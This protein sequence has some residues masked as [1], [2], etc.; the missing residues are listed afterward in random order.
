MPARQR[1]PSWPTPA[2]SPEGLYAA[3][4]SLYSR[5]GGGRPRLAVAMSGGGNRAAAF[6][7]GVLSGLHQI[8]VLDDVDVISAVSG[9]S[10]ALSWFLLQHYY[11]HELDSTAVPEDRRDE[12][13]FDPGGPYQK[14]LEDHAT[15]GGISEAIMKGSLSAVFDGVLFNALRLPTLVLGASAAHLL[16]E[17]SMRAEYR[18]GLQRTYQ[19]RPSEHSITGGRS[20]RDGIIEAAEHLELSL[21]RP[22]V[23]FP[24]MAEFAQ[25]A[26][27]PA[28]VFNTTVRPPRPGAT[29][30]IGDRLME[31]S[32]AGFGSNSYG[33][34]TWGQTEQFG[35]EP[36]S[37]EPTGDRF[38]KALFR[39]REVSPFAT[40]RSFN[41]APVIS[42]AALSGTNL[43]RATARRLLGLFNFGLEYVVP[44][45][46]SPRRLARISDG[47]HCENLGVYGLLRRQS[48]TILIVDSEY[49][50]RFKFGSLRRLIDAAETELNVK[51]DVPDI[52]K[53]DGGLPSAVMMGTMRR[54]RSSDSGTI[55]Y[56]KL[57]LDAI[58]QRGSVPSDISDYS[59]GHPDFPQEST[60]NQH[61][62]ALRFRAYRALGEHYGR[63]AARL[64][65]TNSPDSGGD[66]AR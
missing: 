56:I 33:Y 58:L 48:Q 35:W 40:L 26:R 42:G 30:P 32:A 64:I 1:R 28:F 49:D 27:L 15:I 17:S 24:E 11:A 25:R 8:G 47:G 44:S 54:D 13:L 60:A 38:L 16:N 23:T 53:I 36:G 22:P 41:I 63:I 37:A 18:N 19:M 57:A 14:Y 66:E 62:S 39:T 50:P 31:F 51:V 2:A 55:V 5:P 10:Y 21:S 3:E 20:L 29:S 52:E 12:E 45:M 9:G 43:D 65:A 7:I 6:S 61:F 34:A 59:A 4:Q 46:K